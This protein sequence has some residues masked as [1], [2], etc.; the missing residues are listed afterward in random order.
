MR[1]RLR[2][3]AG[4]NGSGKSTIT[5]IIKKKF[6]IGIYVNADEIK[7]KLQEKRFL[8][9]SDYHVVVN[10][11]DFVDKFKH[12]SLAQRTDI[13]IT[14]D[15]VRFEKNVLF[16][17]EGTTTEDY[18]IS[19]I[20]G[21]LRNL[22]LDSSSRFTFETVMS[23]PSKIE[24]LRLA[25]EKGFKVYLYFV[26]LADPKLNILRVQTRVAQGGHNV[27]ER[28]I[29]ERYYRSMNLLLDAIKIADSAY[30]FDNSFGEHKLIAKKENAELCILGDYVP[31][32]FET[33]VIS[34]L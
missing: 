15:S 18:F 12:S 29:E 13:E 21:Y 9:F 34:K 27:D 4:P 32:W 19:F 11:N 17:L 33:Y 16:Q 22:L 23:H 24:E 8:N 14:L 5:Q 3:F 28:K 10:Y 26:T 20:A 31:E 7:K 25:K 30:L 6:D 2:V 1:K